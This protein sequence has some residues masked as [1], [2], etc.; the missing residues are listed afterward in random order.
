MQQRDVSDSIHLHTQSRKSN[1]LRDLRPTRHVASRINRWP[2]SKVLHSCLDCGLDRSA[3]MAFSNV[4]HSRVER[5]G[6]W[7]A[8]LNLTPDS[9]HVC[10]SSRDRPSPASAS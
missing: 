4:L 10:G 9:R 7:H 2:F 1:V 5:S 3:R 6:S 8:E